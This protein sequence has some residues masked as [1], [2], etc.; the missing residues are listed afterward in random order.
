MKVKISKR[1]LRQVEKSQEW[2]IANR[3]SARELF[4]EE[5]AEATDRLRD[6]PEMGAIYTH[7]RTGTVRRVLLPRTRH[8]LYYRYDA[9]RQSITVLCVWGGPR[10][11]PP[12]L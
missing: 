4:V 10:Q 2:W 7:H 9:E 8:H 5:F 12:R 6:A 11:H 1:A 3:P